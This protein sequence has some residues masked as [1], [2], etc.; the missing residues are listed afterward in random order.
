MSNA[1]VQ[2]KMALSR[3]NLPVRYLTEEEI[4][5]LVEACKK[6]RDRLLI[7]VLFQT[8]VRISEALALTPASIR[9]FEK[10]GRPWR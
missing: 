2:R 4:R 6:E 3:V 10:E 8:G 5:Q 1:L 7:M 9:N